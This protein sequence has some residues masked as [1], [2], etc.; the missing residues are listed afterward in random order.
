VD[1]LAA[2]VRSGQRTALA[3]QGFSRRRHSVALERRLPS[4]QRTERSQVGSG[5][6]G[7]WERSEMQTPR[8]LN[9]PLGHSASSGMTGHISAVET[10]DPSC[11]D[12]GNANNPRYGAS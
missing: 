2:Q 12:P 8:H 5:N 4:A 9:F 1:K 11:D 3:P 10:Q 6:D 7:H